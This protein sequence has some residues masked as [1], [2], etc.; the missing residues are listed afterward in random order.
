MW[1]EIFTHDFD[2]GD[3]VAII[4][5]DTQGIFDDESTIKDCTATFAISM[6]LASVQCY[7]VMQN[8]QEDDLQHLQLFTEYGR[9]VLQQTDEKPF[10]NLLF[11]VRDWPYKDEF[12]FGN[13]QEFIDKKLSGN[14][15]QTTEMKELRAQIGQSFVKIGCWLLAHP[16][17][18]VAEGQLTDGNVQQ[19]D[20]RFIKSVEELV[21]SLL[22]PENLIIKQINGQKVRVCD[23]I[24]YMQA[25]VDVFNSDTL[26]EPKSVLMVLLTFDSLHM[27]FMSVCSTF[28]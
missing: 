27:N 21:P 28:N 22:A 16:G 23:L 8:V 26:P 25:Y 7:N 5:L 17:S 2:G 19:I 15:K 12:N 6:M 9:L 24:S 10:Q 11:V 18:M 3:K 13:G 1:S 20:S 14:A 4:L